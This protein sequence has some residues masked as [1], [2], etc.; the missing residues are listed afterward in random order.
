MVMMIV[1][2]R[3]FMS[4][5][6]NNTR[7][8]KKSTTIKHYIHWYTCTGKNLNFGEI[9]GAHDWIQVWTNNLKKNDTKSN[10][11]HGENLKW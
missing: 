5:V 7:I 2:H 3:L 1:L 9:P 11:D 8:L 10:N 6:G 4:Y